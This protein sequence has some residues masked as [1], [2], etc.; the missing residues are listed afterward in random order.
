MIASAQSEERVSMKVVAT[1][2]G[3]V[4]K[5]LGLGLTVRIQWADAK[6]WG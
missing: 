6:V 1:C 4:T 2:K 3:S 5:R